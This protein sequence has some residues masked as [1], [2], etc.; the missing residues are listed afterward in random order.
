V[1]QV[2]DAITARQW[3]PRLRLFCDHRFEGRKFDFS[4]ALFPSRL[5]PLLVAKK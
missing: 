1:P 5:E 4:F 2:I 3:R